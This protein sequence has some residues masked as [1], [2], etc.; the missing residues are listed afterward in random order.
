MIGF[1]FSGQGAQFAGMGRDLAEAV[2]AAMALFDRAN[3]ALDFDLK[4]ACFNGPDEALV[5]SDVCQP[6]IFTMSMACLAAFQNAN[7]GVKPACAA[8]LSLGEW[9]ALC[10]A[11]V[12]KFEDALK[13]LQM[14]GRWMQE[15]CEANPG[16]MLSVMNAA[17][18]QLQALCDAAGVGI[19][20]LNSASQVVLSGTK[21]GIEKAK[22]LCAEQKIKSIPLQVAGAFHSPLMASAGEKLAAFIAGIPFAEPA[23]PVFANVTGQPHGADI[24]ATMLRQITGTVRWA[25]CVQNMIASGVSSFI[26]FGPGKV[27]SGLIGRINKDVKVQNIQDA[28]SLAAIIL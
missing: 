7:P 11:G 27:V 20:N 12:L 21:D 16:G 19:A 4:S 9:T 28:A 13:I 25:D 17:P 14:R 10:A 5:K 24:R 15:A 26:E 3:E 6:A 2:P 23:F 8:G 18:E 1:V 22:A